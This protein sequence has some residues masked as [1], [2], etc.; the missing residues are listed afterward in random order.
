MRLEVYVNGK[1]V[2]AAEEP[3]ERS[4]VQRRIAGSVSVALRKRDRGTTRSRPTLTHHVKHPD[5]VSVLKE[6]QLSPG[7]KVLIRVL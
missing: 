7:D 6:V 3:S 1:F 4:D 5:R 2:L